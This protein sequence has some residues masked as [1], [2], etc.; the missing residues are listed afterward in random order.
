MKKYLIWA[1]IILAFLSLVFFSGGVSARKKANRLGNDLSIAQNDGIE[2]VKHYTSV[3]FGLEGM[4][5]EKESMLL[6]EREARKL[7]I[8]DRDKYK[9]LYLKKINYSIR[10]EGEIHA[11]LDSIDNDMQLIGI[12]DGGKISFQDLL[13]SNQNA[14]ILPFN[15]WKVNKDIDL[16]GTVGVDKKIAL[17]VTFPLDLDITLGQKKTGPYVVSVFETSPYIEINNINSTKIVDPE[18]FWKK[19]WFKVLAGFG[20]GTVTYHYLTK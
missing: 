11:L 12:G 18:R 7:A 1:I 5:T 16:F 20:A 2:A 19:T 6:T 14:V 15:F 3:I 9:G 8:V 17:E 4:V 10:L 13:G